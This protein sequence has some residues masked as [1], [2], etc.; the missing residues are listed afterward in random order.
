V[1]WGGRRSRNLLGARARAS[2]RVEGI[3]R[4]DDDHDNLEFVRQEFTPAGCGDLA[5]MLREWPIC[6][7]PGHDESLPSWIERIG[8]EYGMSAAALVNS[9]DAPSGPRTCWRSPMRSRESLPI[10]FCGA[11]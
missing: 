7:R 3:G 9:I 6:P 10:D 5:A 11:I 2:E 8:R 4:A 1:P